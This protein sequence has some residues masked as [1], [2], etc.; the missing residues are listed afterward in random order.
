LPFAAAPIAA[1]PYR[2]KYKLF[3]DEVKKKG[4]LE[5]LTNRLFATK[6]IF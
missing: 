3:V 2:Q 5:K 6:N 4:D 1:S